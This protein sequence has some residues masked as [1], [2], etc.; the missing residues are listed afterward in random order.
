MLDSRK[1]G[2]DSVGE[3]KRIDC[4]VCGRP[5]KK[6]DLVDVKS[7]VEEN[8]YDIG[9]VRI[10]DSHVRLECDFEHRFDEKGFTL[11]EPHELVAVVD[12]AFDERG[13]CTQFVITSILAGEG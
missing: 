1:T 8:L 2:H 5:L 4:P 7:V 10:V 12:A 11:D 9:G 13:T 6:D 3:R